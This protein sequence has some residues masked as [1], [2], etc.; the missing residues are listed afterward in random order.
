[1]RLAVVFALLI[2]CGDDGGST[3]EA[4]D[5]STDETSDDAADELTDEA[6]DAPDAAVDAPDGLPA[7]CTGP[8]LV[9]AL[10]A[11]WGSVTRVLDAAYFGFNN[12]DPRTIRVEAYNGAAPGCPTMQSP[13]PE[14]TLIIAF[15]PVPTSADPSTS[16]AVLFDWD[17]AMFDDLRGKS[18]TSTALTPVAHSAQVLAMD[19]SM[20]F[21]GGTLE[22]HFYATHC[23][24]LDL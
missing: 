24:S 16:N 20:T 13:T 4:S 3:D 10:Q 15:V 11:R 7:D 17:A 14:Q 9:T 12:T 21:D 23:D 18:A 1:M 6:T 8:C 2:G 22:G 19:V 5:D